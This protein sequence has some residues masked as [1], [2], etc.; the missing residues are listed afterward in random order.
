MKERTKKMNSS[1]ELLKEE[2]NLEEIKEVYYNDKYKLD[3]DATL[4]LMKKTDM[5][6]FSDNIVFYGLDFKIIKIDNEDE[7]YFLTISL[8]KP[9]KRKVFVPFTLDEY[10][11]RYSQEHQ[12]RIPFKTEEMIKEDEEY[13][14]KQKESREAYKRKQYEDTKRKIETIKEELSKSETITED[15]IFNV[16]E[17]GLFGNN[18]YLT[19][20]SFPEKSNSC[21]I[22][23]KNFVN[24]ELRK[25]VD[26]VGYASLYKGKLVVTAKKTLYL[27]D[28][29][30]ETELEKE[31]KEVMKY[32]FENKKVIPVIGIGCDRIRPD[33]ERRAKEILIDYLEDIKKYY[34]K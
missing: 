7:K 34:K 32:L 19:V 25:A 11:M 17:G 2:V 10:E 18:A 28:D 33:D 5:F 23:D 27:F 26:Y 1:Y 14:R 13:E 22:R 24:E 29:G 8:K 12:E 3:L 21:Y 15:L 16:F 9:N 31:Y 6:D 20:P 30:E 4:E